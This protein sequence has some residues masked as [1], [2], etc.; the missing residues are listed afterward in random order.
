MTNGE[1]IDS[2]ETTKSL[3][4]LIVRKSSLPDTYMRVIDVK[5][6]RSLKAY[7]QK[8]II[9]CHCTKTAR[10]VANSTWWTEVT[11]TT[12]LRTQCIS[13]V[14]VYNLSMLSIKLI[15]FWH[16]K[17]LLISMK[18]SPFK[19]IAQFREVRETWLDWR[20][21]SHTNLYWV[22]YAPCRNIWFW[23]KCT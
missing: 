5:T 21:N 23:Q 18:N 15:S 9:P 1:V 3:E 6:Q 17:N 10:T 12:I 22:L 7:N 20:K 14:Q 16:S 13:V 2:L 4:H 19:G 11:I 8:K